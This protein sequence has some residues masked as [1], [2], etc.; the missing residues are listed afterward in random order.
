MKKI[1]KFQ[2]G[3]KLKQICKNKYKKRAKKKMHYL[4]LVYIFKILGM[5]VFKFSAP[6]KGG[7]GYMA[8]NSNNENWKKY[9]NLKIFYQMLI[10]FN[11]PC[12]KKN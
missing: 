6:I 1:W 12:K 4:Q 7:N 3:I 5:Q 9:W 2:H 10:I 11:Y 8:H